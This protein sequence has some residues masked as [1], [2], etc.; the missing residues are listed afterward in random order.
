MK[1]IALISLMASSILLAGGYKVPE[2]SLNGVALGA[3]NVAHNKSA[4]TAYY[5]PANMVFMSDEQRVELALTYIGLSEVDYKGSYKYPTVLGGTTVPADGHSEKEDFLIPTIHYVS[6]SVDGARYGLSIFTPAGLSKR[7]KDQPQESASEEFT[8]ETVEINPSVALPIGNKIGI[9][10]GIRA[11]YSKG[12][13]KANIPGV[14]SQDMEG[15]SIDFGYNLALAYKATD[16]LEFALTYRSKIDL[17]V[18]GDADLF[19]RTAINPK[20]NIDATVDLPVPALFNAAVAYTLPTKTTIEFVYERN[21]WHSYSELD[22][23]YADTTAEAVFGKVKSKN[24]KDTSTYRLGITQE[25]DKLTLMA[26][27]VIDE[28]PIPESTLSYELPDSDSVSV[29]F[30]GRYS[31]SER[32]DIGL[33]ALYSMRDDRTVNN[34]LD[35]GSELHGE[36]TDST[37]LMIS[38]GIEY[39]F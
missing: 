28:T 5:N 11:L 9:A 29:S 16:S 35:N 31:I 10:I 21:Y 20:K 24:W 6:A 1:K 23:N 13:V 30:G 4:D 3:A 33:S 18:E 12:Y 32:M 2:S 7:W 26:G 8:L 27:L 19:H 34:K 36:F 39:K 14:F 25:L 22:F 17:S 38:A 15:D 37:V